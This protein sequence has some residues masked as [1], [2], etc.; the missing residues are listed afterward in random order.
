MPSNQGLLTVYERLL[1][2]FGPQHWWPAETPF[3]VV[4]GA[5]LTQSTAWANV[6]RAIASLKAAAALTPAAL[7]AQDEDE[8]ATLIR[9][10]G[11][12]RVKARKVKAFVATLDREYGGEL[13]R[14]FAL[15]TPALRERLLAIYGVGPETADS[16]CLYAAQRPLFVVDAYTR[17]IGSRLGLVAPDVTYA[18]L[19]ALFMESLAPDVA[20][21]NEYHALLV[22]HGKNVCRPR[23]D[24]PRCVL[25]DLCPRAGLEEDGL[26]F[27]QRAAQQG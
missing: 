10:S 19:Q 18:A 21:Y 14:L 11:Y 24:C 27:E 3:E 26:G 6:A 17:R 13:A 4:I 7:S 12:F 1:T 16:I 9:P 8:L 5:I 22:C 15:P 25:A 23:P 20:L 2:Q